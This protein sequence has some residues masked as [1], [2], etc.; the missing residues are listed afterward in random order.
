LQGNGK[1][2]FYLQV[3]QGSCHSNLTVRPSIPAPESVQGRL[4]KL[5]RRQSTWLHQIIITTI[6]TADW[7][8]GRHGDVALGALR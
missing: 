7:K 4:A 6:T 3:A 1:D 8:A 2:I 5:P